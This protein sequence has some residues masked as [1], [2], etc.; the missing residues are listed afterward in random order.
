MKKIIFTLLLSI[1]SGVYAEDSLINTDSDEQT[2]G[3]HTIIYSKSLQQHSVTAD[4]SIVVLDTIVVR[5]EYL[6]EE[7][8][9]RVQQELAKMD[10][11]DEQ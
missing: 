8:P 6:P 2:T 11:K 9:Q 5:P 10:N 7:S 3:A 4:D 1:Q